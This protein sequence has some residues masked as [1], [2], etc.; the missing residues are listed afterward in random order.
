[1]FF[2][3]WA[4]QP[5]PPVPTRRHNPRT[6]RHEG[7]GGQ[8]GERECATTTR[9]GM[10]S[11]ACPHKRFFFFVITLYIRTNTHPLLPSR[12]PTPSLPR[13]SNRTPPPHPPARHKNSSR[14]G[15][16]FRVWLHSIYQNTTNVPY[17]GT[18]VVSAC[19]P[20][21][22]ASHENASPNGTRFRVWLHSFHQTLLTCPFGHVSS[23]RQVLHPS[24]QPDTKTRPISGRVFV[25]AYIPSLPEH[26]HSSTKA[27]RLGVSWFLNGGDIPPI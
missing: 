18:L 25:S 20:L 1:M 14:L 13:H 8:G 5:F 17:L 3:F 19:S 27:R 7:E 21:P 15:M 10:G 24:L 4:S 2:V 26:Y 12:S 22:P 6:R 11:R 23:V 9:V 16:S